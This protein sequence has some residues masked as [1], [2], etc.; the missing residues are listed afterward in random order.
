MAGA[1]ATGA[2]EDRGAVR[3]LSRSPAPWPAR[4]HGPSRFDWRGWLRALPARRRSSSAGSSPGSR[5]ASASASCFFRGRG[6]AGPVGAARR[7]RRSPPA[8]R[9][10]AR[11]RPVGFAVAARAHGPVRRLCGRR[12]RASDASRR[13]CSAASPSGRSP[14]SSRA[15][16]SGSA[17]AR[18]SSGL[19]R[20]RQGFPP[21]RRPA[22]RPRDRARAC[23]PSRPGDFIAGT[24]APCCRRRKRRGPGGYDFARDAY[25]QRHRRGRLARR[26]GRGAPA[27]GAAAARSD[28]SPLTIDSGPQRSDPPDRRRDRRTGRRGRGGARHRQARL[29]DRGHQ[30]D[31]ARAP[32]STT[33]SRSP[34]CTWCSP[35][36][37]FSG[38]PGR[39]WRSSPVAA[40]L[41]PCK[42]IAAVVAMIGAIAY[43][44]F[45]GS[46]VA[47]ERS[48]IMIL[49]MLGAI[50]VD[51]PALSLRNLA[52]SALIVLA[53]EPE[54]LLGP[55][56]QMSYAAVAAPDRRGGMDSAAA[57][58]EEPATGCV[59]SG[60]LWRRRGT[61]LGLVT[62]TIVA[63]LATAPVQRLSFPE[64]E[65]VRPDRQRAGAAARL[66]RRHA[67][68]AV[69]GVVA[70]PF[71]LDRPLWQVDGRSPSRRCSSV[72]AWVSGLSGS[73]RRSC[74]R[75]GVGRAR[76]PGRRDPVVTLDRSRRCAGSPS[77]R[78]RSGS[79]LAARRSASTSMSIATGTGA[80]LR[81]RDGR[82][83]LVGALVRLHG[84]AMAQGRRRCAAARATRIR[85]HGARCDPLGCIGDGPDGRAVA[86]ARRPSRLRGGLP[87]RRDRR[88]RA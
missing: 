14:A 28:A 86:L 45:S 21:M 59:S 82:L 27:A 56:F 71:G 47:T 64:P 54:T 57:R 1:G 25:F 43:C 23:R 26:Q 83:V 44:V 81:S 12:L 79:A 32:A 24:G 85:K 36:A 3:T 18:S 75:F 77:C 37:R 67:G 74:R 65:P 78:Q 10:L 66:D 41:W 61:A 2:R 58:T 17:E 30:R 4:R 6:T 50:L 63:T 84:R 69:F 51:R 22:A 40:L 68:C 62:T 11:G 87:A 20:A 19:Q 29:I 70:Y 88:S 39:C 52:L 46:E 15:S 9:V 13:R 76:L 48:L 34:A 35:R 80:A 33:S 60:P 72:S 53:R 16:R 7:S 42:K 49:V 55:S 8:S 31:P 5:S 38:S 73:T